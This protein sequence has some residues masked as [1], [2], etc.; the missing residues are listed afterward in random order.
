VD[1][2][3]KG[4]RL[5]PIDKASLTQEDEGVNLIL[6]IDSRIQFLVE[7]HLKEAVQSK[8][9]KGASPLSW[10]QTGE[11]LPLPM[12]WLRSQQLYQLHA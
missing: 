8:G 7:T 12:K 5:S 11:I 1:R 6:T 10:I 2:D 3:A 4:K 9:A